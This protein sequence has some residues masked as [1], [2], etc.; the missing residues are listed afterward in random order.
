MPATGTTTKNPPHARHPLTVTL[1]WVAVGVP[2]LW[3]IAQTVQKAL[4]LFQT[5]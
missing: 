2:L 5:R 1:A 3:G 4:A